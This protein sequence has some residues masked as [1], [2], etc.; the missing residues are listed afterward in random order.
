MRITKP[1]VIILLC[2]VILFL[3]GHL[4]GFGRAEPVGVKG[5]P[6]IGVVSIRRVFGEC[7][8]NADYRE[9]TNAEQSR[10]LAELEKLSS[11]I[12]SERAGLRTLK[13]GSSDY[14][15]AMRQSLNKQASLQA[16]QQFHKQQMELKDQQFTEQ[17]YQDILQAAGEVAREEGFDLVFDK[18]EAEFPS[19]SANELMMTIRTHKLLYSEGCIDITEAVLSRLDA[20]QPQ[21]GQ[22]K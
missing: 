2:L 21:M 7:K 5:G 8:R 12:E 18:D 20:G 1:A 15:E 9:K 11:E 19:P 3:S 13:E 16:M 10:I 17:L 14:L 4:A 22:K 6:K